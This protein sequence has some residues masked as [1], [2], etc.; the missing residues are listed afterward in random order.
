Y[1]GDT[2]WVSVTNRRRKSEDSSG[3]VSLELRSL[4]EIVASDFLCILVSTGATYL[5][6]FRFV[7]K[8]FAAPLADVGHWQQDQLP[9]LGNETWWSPSTLSD[10]SLGGGRPLAR[11]EVL[12]R[13]Y[14]VIHLF[15]GCAIDALGIAMGFV[16]VKCQR[17]FF[18]F[19]SRRKLF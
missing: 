14:A 11:C 1:C 6:D 13:G 15:F 9:L 7:D 12:R 3:L 18:S 16:G 4:S 17:S 10:E 19:F 5:S 8:L 2:V